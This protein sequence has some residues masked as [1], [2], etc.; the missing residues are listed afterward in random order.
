MVKFT[1]IDD[2]LDA[3]DIWE[4]EL[5]TLCDIVRDF[6]FEEAI[7]WNNPCFQHKGRNVVGLV[8][9]KAY[10]GLWFYDG[11]ELSDPEKFLINAQPGKTQMMLQW[12]MTDATDIQADQLKPYLKEAKQVAA[13]KTGRT[14]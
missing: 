1:Q 12:R 7:R 14:G 9:F 5:R 3:R 8:G 4:T 6:A 2:W 13:A 11:A 10:F